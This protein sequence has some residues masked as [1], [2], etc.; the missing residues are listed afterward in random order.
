MGHPVASSAGQQVPPSSR[1]S[2]FGHWLADTFNHAFGNPGEEA[3][4][5]PPPI[6]TQPYSEGRSS[7]RR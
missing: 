3:V 2:R 7:R 5:R 6:G 1:L 4:H